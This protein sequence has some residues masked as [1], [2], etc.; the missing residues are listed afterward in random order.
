[1]ASESFLAE[2]LADILRE[3]DRR[4]VQYALAGGMAFS[5]LVEPR[6]TTDIDVLI[7]LDPPSR[8]SIQSL[9]ASVFESLIVHPAPMVLQG[10]SMWRAVGVHRREEVVVD[11]LLANSVFLR[12]ALARKQQIT[13]GAQRVSVLT[14]EDLVLMKMLAGRLQDQADLEKIGAR[15][16]DLH[17]DWAYVDRWR[18]MLGITQS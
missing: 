13:L 14:L 10:I 17:I 4:G 12:S 6:A 7:L 9:L 16:S 2:A 18:A 3:F 11:F 15:K 1:M 5:A 8:E